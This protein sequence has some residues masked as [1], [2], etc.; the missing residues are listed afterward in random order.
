MLRNE[1]DEDF[2]LVQVHVRE[3][4]Q[5]LLKSLIRERYPLKSEVEWTKIIDDLITDK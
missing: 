2:R 3:T 1:I 5:V 4:I